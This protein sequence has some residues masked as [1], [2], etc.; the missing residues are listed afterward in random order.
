VNALSALLSLS[1]S[2]KRDR[3]IL[4]TPQEIAQQPQTWEATFSQLYQQ[5]SEIQEFLHAA[6]IG[7]GS[8]DV[9][10]FLIGAGTSDYIGHSLH[11][12]LRQQWKCEVIPVASTSL[13]TEFD[14]FLLPGRRYLW[15]SF[16]RSGDSPEG[17]QALER[18]LDQYPHVRHL[19]ITC[20]AGGQMFRAIKDRSGSFGI[21]LDDA[22]NDRGLAMTSSFTNMVLAGQFLAHAWST[23]MYEPIHL[24]LTRAGRAFLPSAANLAHKLVR[25]G[26]QRAC[27]VGS[28]AL[29]GA[30]TE[31]ALKVLELTAGNVLTMSQSTLGLR[32]GPMAALNAET[33]F[34]SL[35]SSNPRRQKYETDLLREVSQK[36][37]A[38][39]VVAISGNQE[40]D[41]ADCADHW[42]VPEGGPGIPDLYRPPLD[43]I[44]GQ[45]LGL[46]GSLHA[47]LKPDTPSPTGAISRVVQNVGAY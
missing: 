16:S 28:A 9:T 2:D 38:R 45:L 21:V 37:L 13:L 44:F 17:V 24:A 33:L 23:E 15:V 42:L 6:G 19:V 8:S 26:Y 47:G 18:A 3:G 34:V 11:H 7:S 31:S 30:A 40:S 29:T 14:E 12:L 25:E 20:N 32:H 41:L 22:V 27:F 10:V 35:L 36:K 46:F 39:T 43:V 1:N 4:H 5:R